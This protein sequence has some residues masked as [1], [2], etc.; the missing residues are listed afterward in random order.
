M[1]RHSTP[2]DVKQRLPA[3]DDD[4]WELYDTNKDWSQSKDLAKENPDK[5]RNLPI[6]TVAA[7]HIES[8]E[9]NG[10]PGRSHCRRYHKR[11]AY[12]LS[13]HDNIALKGISYADHL[14]LQKAEL[15]G[16][17]IQRQ[18]RSGPVSDVYYMRRS[19]RPPDAPPAAA[20]CT[21][22]AARRRCRSD[23]PGTGLGK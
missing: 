5:L 22:P 3:F 10:S 9:T 17:L 4:V 12:R 13:R 14:G 18:L 19:P 1:T 8:R 21:F 16:M 20:G 23:G 11:S 2:W 15:S 6:P 7:L